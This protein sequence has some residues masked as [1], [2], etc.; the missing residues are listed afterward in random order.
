MNKKG[1]YNYAWYE[2]YISNKSSI[3]GQFIRI[4]DCFSFM[5]FKNNPKYKTK[6]SNKHIN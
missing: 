3:I 5:L 2:R 1:E 4:W 6:Y